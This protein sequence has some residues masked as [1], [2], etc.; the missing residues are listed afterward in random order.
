[1]R[2]IIA[3]GIYCLAAILWPANANA[4]VGPGLGL[5]AVGV[6]AG[7]LLSVAL[8]VFAIVWYPVKRFI[9]KLRRKAGSKNNDQP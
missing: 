3:C 8:A 1:M 5:S 2:H 4:Y 6:I 9:R 7:I